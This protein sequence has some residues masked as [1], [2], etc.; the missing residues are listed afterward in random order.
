MWEMPL[1]LIYHG[2]EMPS[3]KVIAE[4]RNSRILELYIDAIYAFS[5]KYISHVSVL[6][7]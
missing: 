1:Q 2:V 4:C 3:L 6:G 7:I 5:A